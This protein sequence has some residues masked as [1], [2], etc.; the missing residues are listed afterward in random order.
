LVGFGFWV[1]GFW[2]EPLVLIQNLKP[3]TE[4]LEY[5]TMNRK[6]AYVLLASVL[7]MAGCGKPS[8]IGSTYHGGRYGFSF[9]F[10]SGW[11][12]LSDSE[13]AERFGLPKEKLL[14]CIGDTGREALMHVAKLDVPMADSAAAIEPTVKYFDTHFSGRVGGYR[15]IRL[16]KT[17][18]AGK[19][20]VE[21]VFEKPGRDTP[22]VWVR[23]IYFADK[24]LFLCLTF[25][26]PS[27]E[28]SRGKRDL[29]SILGSWKWFN[30]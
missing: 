5:H 25:G 13:A 27:A 23:Q 11:T 20:A 3:K 26:V 8:V 22:K 1:M 12:A 17:S 7:I 21:L 4:N 29:D 28:I 16:G 15:R 9:N 2:R 24:G 19:E 30:R 10:P 6:W 18:L 14:I